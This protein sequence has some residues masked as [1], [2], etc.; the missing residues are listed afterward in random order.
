MLLFL[1]KK[2]SDF[3]HQRRRVGRELL[4]GI[5]TRRPVR[6]PTQPHPSH[7]STS[8]LP[9][10]DVTYAQKLLSWQKFKNYGCWPSVG[11]GYA[12]DAKDK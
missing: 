12:A 4:R 11:I 3:M 8:S 6:T 1:N 9:Q 10:P 2:I 5:S 7:L